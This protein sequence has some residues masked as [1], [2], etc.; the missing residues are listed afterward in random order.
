MLSTYLSPPLLP[1]AF[2]RS[3]LFVDSSF[4]I[5]SLPFV[6]SRSSGSRRGPAVWLGRRTVSA[7]N[8]LATL[9]RLLIEFAPVWPPLALVFKLPWPLALAV[10]V[11]ILVETSN[12]LGRPLVVA[13]PLRAAWS[14]IKAFPA[15]A[16]DGRYCLSS[17]GRFSL[18]ILVDGRVLAETVFDANDDGLFEASLTPLLVDDWPFKLS[19]TSV[20][21]TERERNLVGCPAWNSTYLDV[22]KTKE[23]IECHNIIV[24]TWSERVENLLSN[25]GTIAYHCF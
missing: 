20:C 5:T 6:A 10:D 21:Q 11:S 1:S 9:E 8:L 23:K 16:V 12:G 3:L 18:S 14:L 4:L 13:I 24:F 22:S 19:E 2:V 25:I 17:A 15:A 7:R